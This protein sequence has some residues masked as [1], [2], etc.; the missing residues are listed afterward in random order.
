MR[1][2]ALGMREEQTS[3]PAMTK[4]RDAA[5]VR[6][7]CQAACQP[8]SIA[9]R[10]ESEGGFGLRF[11][12]AA[13]GSVTTEFACDARYQGYPD[14]LH[15]GIVALVLDA[16][17]T[18]CLFARGVRGYTGK[19]QVRYRAPV[20]LRERAVIRAWVTSERHPLYW[21]RAELAQAGQVCAWAEAAFSG[22]RREL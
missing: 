6:A 14:R 21:V 3:L 5:A 1:L 12:V 2:S 22:E 18:N 20:A 11:A 8:D 4:A 19:M 13:D 17:M 10:P 16:A 9:V 7:A 15:G